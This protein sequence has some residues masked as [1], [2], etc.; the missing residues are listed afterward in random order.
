MRA[1]KVLAFDA[2][3]AEAKIVPAEASSSS[4]SY[5]YKFDPPDSNVDSDVPEEKE[6]DLPNEAPG[7]TKAIKCKPS[8]FKPVDSD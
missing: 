7:P 2:S 4:E 8:K 3:K 6:V 1:L 5:E